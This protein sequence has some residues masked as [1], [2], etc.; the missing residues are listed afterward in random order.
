MAQLGFVTAPLAGLLYYDCGD[1]RITLSGKGSELREAVEAAKSAGK[2][3]TFR[4]RTY[5]QDHEPGKNPNLKGVR[6]RPGSMRAMA[7]SGKG[8]LWLDEH[9]P[10]Q[11][12]G[13]IVASEAVSTVEG[14]EVNAFE[15]VFQA[16]TQAGLDRLLVGDELRFSIGIGEQPSTKLMCLKCGANHLDFNEASG[17]CYHWPGMTR[18]GETFEAEYSEAL[19]QETS[20]THRPAVS[21]SRTGTLSETPEF[22]RLSQRKYWI[23]V[24]ALERRSN[25]DEKATAMAL[26]PDTAPKPAAPATAAAPAPSTLA[27]LALAEENRL[28]RARSE[29]QDQRLA[30]LE[31]EVTTRRDAENLSAVRRYRAEGKFPGVD[32]ALLLSMRAGDPERFD[33]LAAATIGNPAFATGQLSGT[34]AQM[35]GKSST[36]ATGKDLVALHKAK[37]EEAT[38]GKTLSA[39]ERE[40]ISN[41]IYNE[42]RNSAPQDLRG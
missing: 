17:Q 1:D 21:G 37:V 15:Q 5:V 33:L 6:I 27:E 41:K 8:T 34:P 9:D 18:D 4:A 40:A 12:L 10:K 28:L 13:V 7:R 35:P 29:Q 11:K 36:P 38:A 26:S 23:L 39:A 30:A 42:L 31:K 3:V 19:L 24:D 22:D 32:E 14:L 16:T 2:P 25:P 20:T